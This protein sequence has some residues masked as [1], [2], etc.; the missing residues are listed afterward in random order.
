MPRIEC[1]LLCHSYSE[2]LQ[3]LYTG[4]L[5]LHRAGI[6]DLSQRI[7]RDG[8]KYADGASHLQDAGH[9]H[10]TVIVDGD[11]RVHFDTHDAMEVCVDE[12]GSSDVY[13]KRSFS[14]HYVKKLPAAQQKKIFP[15]GLNYRVL[16]DQVDWLA[17]K[18]GLIL[19]RGLRKK[20]SAVAQALDANNLHSFQPRIAGMQS[21][22]DFEAAPKIL[23]MVAAYDPYDQVDRPVEKIEERSSNNE[24]RAKC[25]RM[26]RREFKNEFLGGFSRSKYALTHYPDLVLPV[27]QTA[28]QNYIRMLKNFPI[29]IATTGLH[30]STG[31]KLAEYVTHS[32][33]II[34]EE[35]RYSIPGNFEPGR[36]YLRLS[37]AGDCVEAA[38]QL[39]TD[40]YLRSELMV[41][42]A[43][44]YRSYLRPDALVAHALLTALRRKS[45]ANSER[46]LSWI[47]SARLDS[48][49][50]TEIRQKA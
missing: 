44:Y 12:L 38:V 20:L 34:S 6:I 8:I 32:K 11:I 7:V 23:F 37:T 49:S 27:E 36:N 13:F 33:A 21:F 39:M 3:Q 18:R 16:P 19:A 25:I 35:L 47:D 2:H 1:Q 28:Q 48:S 45:S 41:N 46:V 31:W 15:L 14:R 22:P 24:L 9:A 10:L 42:N 50:H 43:D 30:G 40:K 17:A 4:F 29:C 5:F 26:L